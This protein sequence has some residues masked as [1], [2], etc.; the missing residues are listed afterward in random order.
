MVLDLPLYGG[1][2]YQSWGTLADS[3]IPDFLRT[4][5]IN[6]FYAGLLLAEFGGRLAF[7]VT[8]PSHG[9]VRGRGPMTSIFSPFLE[10]LERT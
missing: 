1:L 5:S 3:I 4:G 9:D 10:V 6:S 8:C 2:C 7:V